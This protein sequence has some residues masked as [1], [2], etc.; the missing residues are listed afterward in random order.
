LLNALEVLRGVDGIAFVNFDDTDVVRH[1]LVQRIVKAYDRYG[2]MNGP[3]R[4]LALKLSQDVPEPVIPEP[5]PTTAVEIPEFP[6][7]A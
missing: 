1:S 7:L 5:P 2:E 4:Q 6:S 3:G